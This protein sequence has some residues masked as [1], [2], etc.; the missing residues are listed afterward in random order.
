M[1]ARATHLWY[2]EVYRSYISK[3]PRNITVL[4]H[5][6]FGC[7]AEIRVDSKTLLASNKKVLVDHPVQRMGGADPQRTITL[8]FGFRAT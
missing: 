6:R 3:N 2:I 8:I 5:N 7:P 1:R 4:Q